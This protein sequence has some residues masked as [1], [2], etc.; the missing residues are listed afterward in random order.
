LDQEVFRGNR[1]AIQFLAYTAD[2]TRLL[3]TSGDGFLWWYDV[4]SGQPIGE[5]LAGDPNGF[6]VDLLLQDVVASSAE[7]LRVWNFDIATW[8]DLACRR[9]ARN[10]TVEEWNRYLPRGEP[11]RATC[12]G[13]PAG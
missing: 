3:A 4:A 11:Y 7:G 12:A 10:L 6:S 8:P 5:P 2:G 1:G 13:Y 9:A